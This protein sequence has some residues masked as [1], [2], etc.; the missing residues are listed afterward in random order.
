MPERLRLLG[1]V[2]LLALIPF[3]GGVSGGVALADGSAGQPI[4]NQAAA[5]HDRATGDSESTLSNPV[6]LDITAVSGLSVTPDDA[7]VTGFVLSGADVVRRFTVTNLANRDDRFQVI[8]A[9]VSPPAALTGLFFDLDGNGNIDPGDTPVTLG[10][11]SSPVLPPGG[12]LGVLARYSA[13]G[14][15]AGAVLIL[16]LTAESLEPGAVNGLSSDTGTLR[17]LVGAG[18]IFSDPANP[19]QP[20][21]KTVDDQA[22]V[23]AS[24]GQEVTFALAFVNSGTVPA[25]SA[26]VS[27]PLPPAFIYVA[28]S[29]LLDGS[30][31]SD[32]ADADTAE[33]LGGTVTV[34]FATVAPGESHRIEFGARVDADLAAGTL[35]SNTALFSALG[36]APAD[37]TRALVL[38]DPFGQ[39][40]QGGGSLPLP[41]SVVSLLADTGG[42]LLPLPPLSGAGAVPNTDN[43]N[44]FTTDPAGRFS[45]LPDPEAVGEPGSVALYFL[46]VTLPGFLSRLVQVD[47]VSSASST[48]SAPVFT[49]TLTALDGLP[50]AVPGGF[51][52]TAGPVVLPDISAVA[53]NVPLFPSSG[54]AVTK[55]ADRNHVRIGETVGYRVLVGNPGILA[56]SGVTLT[57]LLPEFLDPVEGA[58]R[59]IAGGAATRIEPV[60]SGRTLTFPLG[61]LPP[62]GQAEISYRARVAP[63]A[64][65][66]ALS[67]EATVSGLLPAGEPVSGGPA[68][69]VIF[70]R[71]GIFSFQQALIGRVFEDLDG[72]G[73]FDP[74]EPPLPGVRV[75][76]DN[77]MSVT[78]DS[79]GLYSLPSVPE[80]ARMI[81]LDPSTYPPGLCP[82]ADERLP[83]NGTGR[84]L[85]TPLRG[86]ALLK[87]NFALARRNDCPS[88]P[89]DVGAPAEGVTPDA[90]SAPPPDLP[91][92]EPPP[93]PAP[94]EAGT[95]VREQTEVL[96]PV[97]PGR[98]QVLEPAEGFVSKT[99][100]LDL[101]VRTHR[102][103]TVR[104]AVNDHRVQEDRLGQ[105]DLDD[106]NQ[107]AT[108][109]YVG[110]PLLPG[111]N[112]VSLSALTGEGGAGDSREILVFGRGTVADI[113][114][115]AADESLP[116]DG[117]SA[118]EVRV[119]LLD[120]W[121]HSAQDTR[122]RILT[123]AGWLTTPE[124]AS[125]D[126]DMTIASRDGTAR[127]VLK[128]DLAT[129]TARLRAEY[130]E[131]S[132]ETS[133]VLLPAPGPA[134]LV[135][136]ADV[137]VGAVQKDPGVGKD[138]ATPEDG[139]H[140]R[141]AFFYKGGFGPPGALMTAAYDS[142][143]RLNR[144]A[145]AN[146]LF[147]LDPLEQTYPVMG[148]SSLRFQETLSNSRAFLK[149]EKGRSYLLYG[150]LDPGMGDSR[151]ASYARKLTGLDLN[152]EN[153]QGDQVGFTLARPDNAFAREVIPASG[154]SGFY[155][156]G[157]VPVVPGS[158]TVTL[159]IHDRRNPEEVLS[160]RPLA[161]GTDYDL[162]PLAGTLIFK[163]P[164]DSF[165]GEFDLAEIVVLYEYQ[166]SGFD[167]LS[168]AG[169]GRKSFNSGSTR[170][171][172][173]VFGDRPDGGEEFRLFAAEF[174]QRLPGSGTVSLETAFS[175]GRP[176]NQGNASL[177]PDPSSGGA[178]VRLEYAQRLKALRGPLKLSFLDVD[179][180]FVN[181]Y[182]ASVAPGTQRISLG[183]EPALTDRIRLVVSLQDEEN[184]TPSVDNTRT[185][186]SLRVT[187]QVN[188]RLGLTGGLAHRDFEDRISDLR[189]GS[190]LLTAGFD[191]RP[192]PRWTLSARREQNFGS[193][194]DPSYPDSTFLAAGLRMS[195]DL[196]YFLKFRDSS[197]P[198][199]AI[200]DV[201]AAGLVPPRSRSEVQL[202][203]ETRLGDH[204]TLTSRYQIENGMAGTDSYAVV[205]LGTRLPA[206]DELSVD[207]RGE[208]GL[209]VAGPGDSFES[210]SSGLSWLPR[211]NFRATF[212]YELRNADGFGQT[213]SA[214]AVGKPTED[215]TLLARLEASDASQRGQDT[216]V[217]NFLGGL[218][219][220]PLKRDDY[221]LLFAWKRSDRR[222]GGSGTG[223][224]VRTRSD[225]LSADGV[226]EFTPRVRYFARAALTFSTDTPAGLPAVATTTTLA[227]SRL[228]YR[229][230]RRWDVAG[231]V[232]DVFLWQ[233]DLRRDS[234]GLE[235]G[236]WASQD[237][238]VG[239][240]YGFT[241]SRPLEGE[242]PSIQQGFYFNLTTKLNRILEL[243]KRNP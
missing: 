38:V 176:M 8:S 41:G 93:I 172:F 196:R 34:R 58:S 88:R 189:I 50:L 106:R 241:G 63:G 2:A 154:I 153:R 139:T 213:F 148:D 221:G 129:G 130:G 156:L 185:T 72:D 128:S 215:M 216:T 79:E 202:G 178:A 208:A 77:G 237:L 69:A 155:R 67:N 99:G 227:Q 68:R 142:D 24:R 3:L 91:P 169:E 143:R 198:I 113:R 231:E 74:A 11:T 54:L 149:M 60:Q 164:L 6:S 222:Q 53:F 132:D 200:A 83:D 152:L 110:I 21:A 48:L 55:T 71:Q 230:G 81:G 201:G 90:P 66:K 103:G 44:P 240:G 233:D 107:L 89:P 98:F 220:R 145:D 40:F 101:T 207:F 23:N 56:V 187:G 180:D 36:V 140:G 192:T 188:D 118:T 225:T 17:D 127:A 16:H 61:D 25:Q 32:A 7:V 102:N 80:G 22:R 112:R 199:E 14:V 135:G 134:L 171:G 210:L 211:E 28:G 163:R 190:D 47:L 159:E 116:A 45:F 13:S 236:F 94:L 170:L 121:G 39:V 84:L 120:A 224:E 141:L 51:A 186:G 203:A 235:C 20:P 162:D 78:A 122:V 136:I 42:T 147:D 214:G 19:G 131:L 126:R 87:Q 114:I 96:P 52:L 223:D 232:R 146:R 234:L 218:A 229:L 105:T 75:V 37:S 243:L 205:G 111:P 57:D 150:D 86:G 27:D 242:D 181:P 100:A 64:P 183:A 167:S 49:L 85:R 144:T 29:L 195:Q 212:R 18:A 191:Y 104:V 228:E 4:T 133:V 226:F 12:S 15:P 95:H 59:R 184:R 173:S 204:S 193:G 165:A 166:S 138:P 160:R 217:V 123:S 10:S 26:V 97:P 157:H 1:R 30:P 108:F 65:A 31:Q 115:S 117:R 219:L 137:T 168:W 33:V 76:L 46:R 73:L 92:G 177:G 124:G 158:E 109:H 5:S 43:V 9:T 238:R 209:K 239:L 35:L 194:S 62:G 82:S 182:G 70:V 179:A 206:G 161:R 151:L 175:D 119:D 197:R 174:L 125:R